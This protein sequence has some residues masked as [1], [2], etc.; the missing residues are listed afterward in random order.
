MRVSP[1]IRKI[2]EDELSKLLELYT[3][4]HAAEP[5]LAVDARV[6]DLWQRIVHDPALH[7]FVAEEAGRLAASCTLAVIPNLT[8]GARPYG[9]IE[10]VVTHPD[11]RRR[12]IGTRL[13]R[14]ALNEAWALGC[15][16]VMLMT[17]RDGLEPF[18]EAA[19]FKAGVKTAFVAK[20]EQFV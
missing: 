2:R 18:Y 13:L 17:G 10:N 7:Y 9:V 4:L 5:E 15:Y 12:E 6:A 20:P 3:H 16:K 8:R 11:F 19:G 14:H 1:I